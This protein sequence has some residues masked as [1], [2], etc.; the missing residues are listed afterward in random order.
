MS[1]AMPIAFGVW[2]ALLNNFAIERAAFDG[3]DMGVLQS[4]REVPGFLAFA[5]VFLLLLFKEQT[6]GLLSL[7]LLG[8]GTAATGLFPNTTGLLITTFIM[9]VGFHYF[10]TVKQS[11]TL[12]WIDK[13]EA[14]QTIGK[15]IAAGS[16]ASLLAFGGIWLATEFL[17]LDM[18][19]VYML[20]GGACVLL[21]VIGFVRFP[22]FPEK[23]EQNKKLFLRRRYWLYYALTFM[24]GARRQI[25]V[26]FAGFLMVEKFGF[27]VQ[28]VALMFL[29]NQA[30]TMVAAPR[31]GKLISSWGERRVLTLEYVGL[32]GVFVS[33]AFVESAWFAVV[34]YILDHLFF[35]MAIALKTYFQKIA[36]PADIAPTAGVA[37]TINHIAA[38]VIPA[39]FGLMWLI[40]PSMVFLAGAGMA[41]LSLVLSRLVPENP[42]EGNEVALPLRAIA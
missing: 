41:G 13:K 20:G 21:A 15:L 11:L 38:V 37:F 22:H 26:V 42:E 6:L 5:V 40:S 34:L 31:I 1:I 18:V 29:A 30:I 25:F 24:A 3:A 9:S 27:G 16:F 10:E 32:I 12:Q 17:A 39:A 19:Y 23:T 8:I 28:A 36:D 35:S 14:P 2:Q 33:Y 4:L 7:V